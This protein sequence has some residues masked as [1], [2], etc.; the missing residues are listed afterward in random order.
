MGR[1][2]NCCQIE[3]CLMPT[4]PQISPAA[5]N[6]CIT[7][8]A[9]QCTLAQLYI[10]C[11]FLKCYNLYGTGQVVF[12]WAKS[13]IPVYKGDGFHLFENYYKFRIYD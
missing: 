12:L 10:V 7:K 6:K 5:D 2:S 3:T 9:I 1:G 11:G 8:C 13:N 4:K